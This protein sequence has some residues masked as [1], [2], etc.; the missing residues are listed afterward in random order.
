M[1]DE[2][3]HRR[4]ERFNFQLCQGLLG[5]LAIP[6]RLLKRNFPL[7]IFLGDLRTYSAVATT[8]VIS[9]AELPRPALEETTAEEEPAT[10]AGW[11]DSGSGTGPGTTTSGIVAG[12]AAA[13]AAAAVVVIVVAG[14]AAGI[15]AGVATC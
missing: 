10:E 12:T 9:A 7:G 5:L 6:K 4:G 11:S 8:S 14:T 13:A 1:Y 15:A 3:F 2:A